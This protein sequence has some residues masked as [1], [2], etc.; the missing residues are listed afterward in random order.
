MINTMADLKW[1]IELTAST[2]GRQSTTGE[3]VPLDYFIIYTQNTVE[4]RLHNALIEVPTDLK[5]DYRK[6]LR[7]NIRCTEVPA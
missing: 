7:V 4:R 6:L 1:L 2:T 5:Q 3:L